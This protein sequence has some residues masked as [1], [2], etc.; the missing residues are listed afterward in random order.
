MNLLRKL[1]YVTLGGMK[2]E[3]DYELLKDTIKR[4]FGSYENFLKHINT[5]T[6]PSFYSKIND[7]TDFRKK[8]MKEFADVIGFGYDQIPIYFFKYETKKTSQ[9]SA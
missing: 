2:L 1:S 4:K 7:R 6:S 3:S 9:K 5:M 8:E